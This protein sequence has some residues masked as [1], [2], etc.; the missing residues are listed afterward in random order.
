M[1]RRTAGSA[2]SRCA[3]RSIHSITDARPVMN[4]AGGASTRGAGKPCSASA[5]CTVW[6]A[7]SP[8]A[9]VVPGHAL[10]SARRPSRSRTPNA[11]PTL[12]M[13]NVTSATPLPSRAAQNASSARWIGSGFA[14]PRMELERMTSYGSRSSRAMGESSGCG[15]GAGRGGSMRGNDGGAS[16]RTAESVPLLRPPPPARGNFVLPMRLPATIPHRHT[17]APR[18][19]DA[20]PPRPHPGPAAPLC[21]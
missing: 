8:A 2:A 21:A 3:P 5:C 20:H 13:Q 12:R 15:I 4:G 14:V 10:T 16:V 7:S 11:P 18:T 17:S 1:A 9:S 19:P 6:M